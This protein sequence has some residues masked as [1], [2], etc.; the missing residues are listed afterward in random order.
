M[1]HK[2]GFLLSKNVN[3][4]YIINKGNGNDLWTRAIYKE[5]T[6]ARMAF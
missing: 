4:A 3:E 6:E 2:F 1:T 5:M